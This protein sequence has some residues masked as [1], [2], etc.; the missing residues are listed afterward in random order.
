M[1]KAA[2]SASIN[3]KIPTYPASDAKVIACFGR[4][5]TSEMIP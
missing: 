3:T 2:A 5:V 1:G 4:F